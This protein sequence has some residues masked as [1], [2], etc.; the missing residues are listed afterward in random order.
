MVGQVV[1][2]AEG[3]GFGTVE[4]Y[5]LMFLVGRYMNIEMEVE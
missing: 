1:G 5:L 2:P 3:L 4:K